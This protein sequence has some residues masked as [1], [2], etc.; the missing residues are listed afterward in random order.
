VQGLVGNQ[1][2]AGR[3]YSQGGKQG[4]AHPRNKRG[5]KEYQL[6][7]GWIH[8]DAGGELKVKIESAVKK[9]KN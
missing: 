3:Q 1:K 8:P 9:H 7:D 6:N 5:L 2:G 4:G